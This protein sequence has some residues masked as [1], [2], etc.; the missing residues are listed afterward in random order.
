MNSIFN[1]IKKN[2][3]NIFILQHPAILLL[4]FNF[5]NILV[6]LIIYWMYRDD[7]SFKDS[8]YVREKR[9]KTIWDMLLLST[10]IQAGVGITSI[11]P[12]TNA[13]SRMLI[14]QQFSMIIG[15]IIGGIYTVN[16]VSTS[17]LN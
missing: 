12:L 1:R 4:F 9:E 7:F 15:N 16:F 14:L 2:F 17:S 13:G 5:L 6:F 8:I 10:T 11:Y 3:T